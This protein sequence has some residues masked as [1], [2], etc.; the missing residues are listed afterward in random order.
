MVEFELLGFFEEFI[1]MEEGQTPKCIGVR[2]LKDNPDNRP[3]GY[4]GAREFDLTEP[5]VLKVGHR[6]R[7]YVAS[8][9]HPIHVRTMLQR[10]EGQQCKK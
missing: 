2:V 1:R 8:K 5:I 10:L 4:E 6:E 3:L 7:R 9:K